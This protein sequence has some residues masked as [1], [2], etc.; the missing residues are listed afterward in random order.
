MAN[1]P[2]CDKLIGRKGFSKKPMIPPPSERR[3]NVVQFELTTGCNHG[4]CTFCDMYGGPENYEEKTIEDFRRHV[5]LVMP[6][7]SKKT[8]YGYAS[9]A[10]I[11]AGNALSVD[12][13]KLAQVVEYIHY[14]FKKTYLELS[15]LSVYGNTLDILKKGWDGMENFKYGDHNSSKKLIYW[16]LESG[17]NEVLKIAG[18]GYDSNQAVRAGKILQSVGILNSTMIMP[19]L[20]GVAYFDKHV[21]ETTRVL[22]ETRPK[23]ITFMGLK[24]K[25]NTPYEVWIKRQEKLHENWSLTP[26]EIVEQTAQIIERLDF[27]TKIGIHGDYI[28]EGFCVN[29][30]PMRSTP[31]NDI[32]DARSLAFHLR[33]EINYQELNGSPPKKGFFDFFKKNTN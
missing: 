11:G 30:I 25:P 9:R 29:P 15:R 19:G 23:W 32:H 13:N 26:S 14:S 6:Y 18:K 7:F 8:T 12:S 31:I 24:I 33:D 28:H 17:S 3:F 16:G 21:E 1:T 10:F 27:P 20:G 2:Y 22:N 4:R 5:D